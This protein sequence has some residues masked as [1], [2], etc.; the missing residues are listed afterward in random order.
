MV[1]VESGAVRYKLVGSLIGMK[2]SV[3][4]S[5]VKYLSVLLVLSSAFSYTLIAFVAPEKYSPSDKYG[6]PLLQN[7]LISTPRLLLKRFGMVPP[8]AL[9]VS[10]PKK[11]GPFGL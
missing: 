1:V 6:P 7:T 3:F 10:V 2:W 11:R 4:G 8:T 9:G 5:M